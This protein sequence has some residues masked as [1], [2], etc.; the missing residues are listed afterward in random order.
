MIINI[1][2]IYLGKQLKNFYYENNFLLIRGF[3][4]GKFLKDF[5]FIDLIKFDGDYNVTK[6]EWIEDNTESGPSYTGGCT[7]NLID[8]KLWLFGGV[9][10]SFNNVNND[11]FIYDIGKILIFFK[12]I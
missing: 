3:L 6:W 10:E 5:C 4:G 8:N 7:M 11:L 2:Y 12:K 9:T 1:D